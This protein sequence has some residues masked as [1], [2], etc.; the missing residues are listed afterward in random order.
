MVTP[1]EP[2]SKAFNLF[3]VIGL[4]NNIKCILK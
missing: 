2:T 1:P 4:L 3:L